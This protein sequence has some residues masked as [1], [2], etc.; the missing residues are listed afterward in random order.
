MFEVVSC[1]NVA[2]HTGKDTW[3]ATFNGGGRAAD[4]Y[5][6]FF[7]TIYPSLRPAKVRHQIF[8]LVDA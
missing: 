1:A 2:R 4:S 7:A 8:V 6:V 3:Q 5:Y